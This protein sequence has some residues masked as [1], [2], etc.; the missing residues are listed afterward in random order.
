MDTGA[1]P[2]SPVTGSD[3]LPRKSTSAGV[4]VTPLIATTARGTT[5]SGHM[6]GNVTGPL[7]MSRTPSGGTSLTLLIVTAPKVP[8]DTGSSD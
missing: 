6:V 1:T 3:P 2:S 5:P 4:L 7:Y 8:S